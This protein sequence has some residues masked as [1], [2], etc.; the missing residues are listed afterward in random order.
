MTNPD[1]GDIP[2]AWPCLGSA[3]LDLPADV[4]ARFAPGGS[5][6]ERLGAERTRLTLGAWSWAGVAGIL[7]T[8]DATLTEVEPAELINACHATAARLDGV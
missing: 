5:V 3:T 7:A 1:R 2:E 8:F 6:I 4:V